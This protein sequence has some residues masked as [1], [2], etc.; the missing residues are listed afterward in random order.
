M[1]EL[2]KNTDKEEIY[3]PGKTY[4]VDTDKIETL[5][6]VKRIL[7]FMNL[8]FTPATKD[9]YDLVKHLLKESK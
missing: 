9:S 4:K 5:D 6:D 2:E 3:V 7:K 1:I 8:S